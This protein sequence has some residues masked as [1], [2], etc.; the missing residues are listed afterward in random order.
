MRALRHAAIAAVAIVAAWGAAAPPALAQTGA[1]TGDTSGKRIAMSNNYAGNS[2]RQAMLASWQKAGD[3]AVAAKQLKEV[4]SFT[5]AENQ[6]TEQAAQIQNLTLQGYDAIVVNASSP[7]ALNG[8]IKQACD[9]GIIVV[10]FDSSVTEPCA[11]VVGVDFRRMGAMQV[12]YMAGRGLKGNLL[13]VRGL[14]GGFVDEEIHAGITEALKTHPE[15][16]VVSSV[17]GNWT[18][19]VAQK[20][21]A[22]VLPTL[23]EI[24]AVVTQGGDGYGTAQAF[25]AA[26][27]SIPAIF[28]GNREDELTWWKQQRDANGYQTMSA[29]ISPGCS[30]FALWVAQQVLSGA[31]VPKR[32]V[33]PI[34]VVEQATLDENLKLTAPGGVTT[35][36]YSQQ[37]VIDFIAK[38]KG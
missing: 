30:T 4:R 13:E 7:T 12:E 3:A 9:A 19:T 11:Y 33:L 18:Q 28:M 15:F 23:P 26:G 34:T 16:K 14:A 27:R 17:H 20:E 21:V 1:Q 22:G 38:L 29:A 31:K 24:A 8:A 10:V 2:W 32:F 6:A 35:I 5:T 36:N 37:D 25:R